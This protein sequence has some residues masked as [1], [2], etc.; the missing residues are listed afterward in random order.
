L[1][2][3]F[4]IERA[5]SL[6]DLQIYEEPPRTADEL[7]TRIEN[8]EIVIVGWSRLTEDAI[9]STKGLKMI[10]IWATSCHYADLEAAEQ[11][12]IVVTHVP[13]YAADSVAEFAFALMLAAIRKLT[14]ADRH[15]RTGE[16][17]WRPFGGKE[18]AGKTLGIIGT[19]AI[20]FRVAE[21][22]RAFKMKLLGYDKPEPQKSRGSRIEICGP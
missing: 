3:V 4:L 21:I 22:A 6:G 1:K 9:E 7:K 19:G 18:L 15:L 13:G 2:D 10:S 12:G 16:F 5:R 11:K 8:A 17:D 20:G 14:L